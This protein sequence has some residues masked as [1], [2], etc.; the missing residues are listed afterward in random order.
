MM[1]EE[2]LYEKSLAQSGNY[3][4]IFNQSTNVIFEYNYLA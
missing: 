3:G 2:N 4:G 1:Q